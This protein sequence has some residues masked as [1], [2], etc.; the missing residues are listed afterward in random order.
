MVDNSHI[1]LEDNKE[2]LIIDKIKDNDN[3]YIYL[4]NKFDETDLVVRKEII[5][6]DDEHFLVGLKDEDE[7]EKALRL[8]LDKNEEEK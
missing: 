3:F 4:M 5:N 7:V 1:I 8:F 2:Y 6:E